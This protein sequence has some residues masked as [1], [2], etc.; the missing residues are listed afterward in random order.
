MSDQRQEQETLAGGML[1]TLILLVTF[2]VILWV[3][4]G[5][6]RQNA[7]D[8]AAE[9]AAQAT[10]IAAQPTAAPTLEPTTAPTE[11]T[12]VAVAYSPQQIDSGRNTFLTT[13]AACHGQNGQGIQGL[14]KNLVVSEFVTGLTDEEL[15]QFIIVGRMPGDPLNTT[16]MLMPARGGNP[17]LTDEAILDIVAYLRSARAEQDLSVVGGG[18]QPQPPRGDVVEEPFV[19]PGPVAAAAAYSARADAGYRAVYTVEETYNLSCAG[20]HGMDGS[21]VAGLGTNLSESALWGNG[22]ALFEFLS[23]DAPP[24]NPLDAYPHPVQ[25][26]LYPAMTDS[27]LLE[28]IGYLYT[29]QN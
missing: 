12:A 24:V 21:G 1:P 13:C 16:G 29:L 6:P 17:S 10:E 26:N 23:A 7:N 8:R 11:A 3:L 2:G 25:G 9:A 28:L 20:C 22:T 27:E 19:M 15:V 18:V 5:I 4:L 14:G